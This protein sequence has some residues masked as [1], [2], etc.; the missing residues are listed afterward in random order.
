MADYNSS[1][2]IRTENPGDVVAKIGDGTTPSQQLSVDASGRIIVKL[3]DG[4]GTAITSQVNG[5]QQALDVGINV[6]GVQVDPRAIRALTS[7]D[8]V[9][10][11]QGTSPW[12]TKDQSDG[13]V[14]PGTVAS[15]S[16]LAGGQYNSS[17]P[18]LTTAQQAALQV[19]ASGRLLVGSIAS[20]LPAGTNNIGKVSIQDSSG[21]PFTEANPLP[22]TISDAVAG[23]TEVLD[24]KAATAVAAS[25]SDTHTYTITSGKHL[26]LQKVI[27]SGSGK[28]KMEVKLGT[29]ASEVTKV[30]MFN[31]TASPNCIYEFKS[32]QSLADTSD[33]LI[34]IT[35]LDNQ[36]QNVYSTVEGYE[37]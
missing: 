35:N 19:D 23:S 26:T 4:S 11:D 18:T 30:V 32:P 24:Y 8:V 14:T 15:F 5:A 28:I 21:N 12:V 17:L 27:A 31:S 20:P 16:Q 36:A 1:L 6:A 29:I 22:V 34:I 37:V 25:A 9:T 7:S 3:T 33:V 2:P 10:V 13:P